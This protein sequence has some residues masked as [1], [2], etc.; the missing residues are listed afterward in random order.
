MHELSS[1]KYYFAPDMAPPGFVGAVMAVCCRF[2]T[3]N[4][5][6]VSAELVR[7]R[8]PAGDIL[9]DNLLA[10]GHRANRYFSV[11]F[12][13]IRIA[14]DTAKAVPSTEELEA[15][16]GHAFHTC[17]FPIDPSLLTDAL[18]FH[19]IRRYRPK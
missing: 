4:A 19:L 10:N 6:A 15:W 8:V 7:K 3:E 2:P 14:D 13:G 18:H 16:S 1:T 12:D 17:P 9:I 5:V 11:A